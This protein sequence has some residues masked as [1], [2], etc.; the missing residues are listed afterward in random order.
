MRLRKKHWAIPELEKNELIYFEPMD[1]KGNW[2]KVFKNN[3]PIY[4]ELGA[5][6][7]KFSITMAE[8]NPDIDFIAFEMEANAFVYAGRL[9]KESQV[10]NILG[11]RADAQRLLEFFAEDE[12]DK[13]FINFC[14]PWPK[15]RQHK[16]RLSHPRFLDLYQVVLKNG[17]EIELKTDDKDFF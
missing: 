6:R 7:G 16:R 11:I 13:I 15:P 17:G 1:N 5:G 14:N 4:L 8:K 9:F 10:E 2:R 3:N 12:I